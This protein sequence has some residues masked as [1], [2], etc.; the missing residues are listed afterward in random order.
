MLPCDFTIRLDFIQN[1]V[2]Q[3]VAIIYIILVNISI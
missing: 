2:L 1:M 3:I